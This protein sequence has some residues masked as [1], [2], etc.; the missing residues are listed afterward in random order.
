MLWKLAE[1]LLPPFDLA[2]N[3]SDD[4]AHEIQGQGYLG[5]WG[6][7]DGKSALGRCLQ[8]WHGIP[9][10]VECEVLRS[11][12]HLHVVRIGRRRRRRLR[13]ANEMKLC[14]REIA[15]SLAH[16]PKLI[17]GAGH[18]SDLEQPQQSFLRPLVATTAQTR[19]RRC[20]ELHLGQSHL[21][22]LEREPGEARSRERL[23][24]RFYCSVKLR[25]QRG[26][27]RGECR[28]RI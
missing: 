7:W 23:R 20:R 12:G 26:L 17:S 2:L 4:V 10:E 11:E 25:S 15:L 28:G 24:E 6:D 9:A 14:R 27:V 16:Q 8:R 3:Y 1:A 13:I 21:T 18:R 19:K 22:P 5:N